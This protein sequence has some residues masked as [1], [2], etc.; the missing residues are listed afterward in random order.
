MKLKELRIK[1]TETYAT[2]PSHL[3]GLLEFTGD[4]GTVSVTLSATVINKLIEICKAEAIR[5]A[6]QNAAQIEDSM[7]EAQNEVLLIEHDGDLS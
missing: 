6:K 1:R 5:V 7:V 2:P 3:V 4:T